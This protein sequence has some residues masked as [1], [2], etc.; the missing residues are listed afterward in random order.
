MQTKGLLDQEF[1]WIYETLKTYRHAPLFGVK[2]RTLMVF[3]KQSDG[4]TFEAAFL[5][6]PF[7]TLRSVEKQELERII[8]TE[9]AGNYVILETIDVFVV[10]SRYEFMPLPD[11][12]DVPEA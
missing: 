5:L 10:A 2:P 8:E 7:L 9:F 11:Y 6:L 1:Y 3:K 4:R 12:G